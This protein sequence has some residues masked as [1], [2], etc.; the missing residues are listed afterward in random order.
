MK[1]T[2]IIPAYNEEKNIR[3][4]ISNV[5]NYVDEIIVIDDG[6]QDKT[7]EEAKKANLVLRHIV[8][9]GKGVA[10]KTGVIAALKRK[11]DIIIM[12]DAD[13]QHKSSDIPQLVK[14]LGGNDVV[15]GVRKESEKV[16]F[17]KKI[18]NKGLNLLFRILFGLKVSDTQ[19][20][21]R[22][23]TSDACR[24]LTWTSQGYAVETEILT[25]IKKH[26]LKFVE[27]PIH[28]V[29]LD[30][31][32]GTSIFDGLRIGLKMILWKLRE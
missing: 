25:K 23:F 26:N 14:A 3:E 24:K 16:P 7:S 1:I 22:V 8:N 28:T 11:A 15:L 30:N 9:L 4:V 6:S 29:Y 13:G 21:F 17:V 19:S 20:G 10:L 32:K 31:Y 5:K 27:V 12:I 2:A 18:G